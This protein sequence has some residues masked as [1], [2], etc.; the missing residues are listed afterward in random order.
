MRAVIAFAVVQVVLIVLGFLGLVSWWVAFSPLLILLGV[1][2]LKYLLLIV[3]ILV[4]A[5]KGYK[6]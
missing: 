1:V 6:R 3:N 2:L 5:I 4:I